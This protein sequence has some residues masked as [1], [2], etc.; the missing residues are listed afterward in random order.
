MFRRSQATRPRVAFALSGGCAHG[1]AQVGMLQALFEAHIV[2]DVLVGT[3]VGAMNAVYVAADPTPSRA[4]ELAKI[5]KGIGRKEVFGTSR[6]AVVNAIARRDHIYENSALQTLIRRICP[7]IDL[8]DLAVETHVVTT[9][10][11]AGTPVWWSEG[12]AAPVLLASTS[13]PGVFPPVLMPGHDGPSRHIDGGVTVPV[14]VSYAA[15]LGVDVVYVLDVTA[16]NRPAPERLN[17]ASVFLRSFSISRYANNPEHTSLAGPGQQVIV[18][19]A[20]DTNGRSIRD[21][22]NTTTY[23]EQAYFAASEMLAKQTVA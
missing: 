3:S 21:F 2:P 14:P 20:P 18:L 6:Q 10:L 13:I 17:A 19:P 4:R 1:A 9:D 12:P 11:D 5:W 16:D 15:S 8:A 22:S 23:M 7:V